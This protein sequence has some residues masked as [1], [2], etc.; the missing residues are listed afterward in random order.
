MDKRWLSF[1]GYFVVLVM[2]WV[3]GIVSGKSGLIA[4]AAIATLIVATSIGAALLVT[5]RNRERR[6]RREAGS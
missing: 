2:L 4:I 6:L 1:T 5:R 3:A